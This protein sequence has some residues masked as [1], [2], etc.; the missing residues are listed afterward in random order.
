MAKT[1]TSTEAKQRW[2]DKTYKRIMVSLRTDSEKDRRL[3]QFLE[4][5]KDTIGTSQIFRE[6]LE[7]YINERYPGYFNK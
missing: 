7:L 6:A 3:L 1:H 4:D 2:I 5:Y